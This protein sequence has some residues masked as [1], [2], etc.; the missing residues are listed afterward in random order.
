MISDSLETVLSEIFNPVL[1]NAPKDTQLACP[2]FDELKHIAQLILDDE[3][4]ESFQKFFADRPH[5][6]L[7]SLPGSGDMVLGIISK[8]PIGNFFNADFAVFTVGQ[9]CCGIS[10]VE[11]ERPTDN[12]FTNKLTP[13]KKLQA[14]IGQTDDWNE[15]LLGNRSSFINTGLE[16]LKKAPLFPEKLTNGSFKTRQNKEI[17]NTWN[18]FGGFDTCYISNLIVI[19]RWSKLTEKE[20]KRLLFYNNKFKPINFQIRTYDQLIRQGYDGPMFFW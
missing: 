1:G 6:L 14:A 4:E 5:F 13:A 9:G 7:R 10:L 17:N 15:W 19:G 2:T 8:P 20:Q 16:I 3:S 12:L 11:L 18:A